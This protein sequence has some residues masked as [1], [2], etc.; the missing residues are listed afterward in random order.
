MIHDVTVFSCFHCPLRIIL[1]FIS[2]RSAEDALYTTFKYDLRTF[3]SLSSL[4]SLFVL[5]FCYCFLYL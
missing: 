5:L 2:L 1:A 4:L 3:L